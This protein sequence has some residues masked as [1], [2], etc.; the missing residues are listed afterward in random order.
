MKVFEM[1]AVI[2][3][4]TYF[5]I[6]Y[7]TASHNKEFE[8]HTGFLGLSTFAAS[9][10]KKHISNNKIVR[11][12]KDYKNIDIQVHDLIIVDVNNELELYK[13]IY[14]KK[15]RQLVTHQQANVSGLMMYQYI[16]INNILCDNGYF[17]H[18][19]NKEETYLKILETGDDA[20]I[21][22]LEMYLNARDEI[23]RS[24]YLEEKYTEYFS[25]IRLATDESKVDEL[26]ATFMSKY[27]NDIS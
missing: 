25:E 5:E 19:D 17:I 27:L 8:S 7:L 1:A 13:S 3:C 24:S 10:I 14:L 26:Y 21:D 11:I 15:V 16:N 2:D 22:K 18:D 6:E 12:I 23:A 9:E 4:G 20:L